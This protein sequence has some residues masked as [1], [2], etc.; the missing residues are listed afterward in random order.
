VREHRNEGA[1]L[2]EVL[3]VWCL[4]ALV[5][6]AVLLTY[7]RLPPDRLYHTSVDGLAGGAGRTLVLLNFPIAVVAVAILGVVADRLLASRRRL[8]ALA[9][10]PAL[11]LCLVTLVPGVVNADDLDARLVNALPATGVAL[12]VALTLAAWRSGEGRSPPDASGDALRVAVGG[13]LI[14]LGVPWAFAE[15]GFYAPDPIL[16]DEVPPGETLAA[17]HLG[18]HHGTDGVVLALAALILSRP[19]GRMRHLRLEAVLSSYL[20]LMLAYGVTNAVQDF[21]LEQ[22]VKRDW[23]AREIPDVL[24]PALEPTWAAVLAGAVAVELLWFRPLRRR[25]D[26]VSSSSHLDIGT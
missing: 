24:R 1:G 21:W 23:T 7:A 8:A 26:Y 16:A 17:V 25:R 5:A 22:V 19:L 15:W 2:G 3:A 13:A 14:V 18:H 9:G 6:L 12:V 10:P 20:A 4:L 11:A